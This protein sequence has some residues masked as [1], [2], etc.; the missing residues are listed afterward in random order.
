MKGKENQSNDDDAR[1]RALRREKAEWE[2]EL[3]RQTAEVERLRREKARL[4]KSVR[5][6]EAMAAARRQ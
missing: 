6:K 1:I 4:E 5:D 3:R 2:E